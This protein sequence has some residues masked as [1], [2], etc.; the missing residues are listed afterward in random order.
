[1]SIE[2]T[3]HCDGP[4]CER[5]ASTAAQRMPVGFLRVS[6]SDEPTR[7]FCGWDCLLRFAATIEPEEVIPA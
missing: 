2:R 5:H 3:Y 7:Y 4:E 1:M 6:S